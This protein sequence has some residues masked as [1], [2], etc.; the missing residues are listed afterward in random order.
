L[1]NGHQL[2]KEEVVTGDILFEIAE[3][4]KIVK[5]IP[6]QLTQKF[7]DI[8]PAPSTTQQPGSNVESGKKPLKPLIRKGK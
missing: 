8:A 3:R 6:S 4:Q 1:E 2:E 5:I 7:Q